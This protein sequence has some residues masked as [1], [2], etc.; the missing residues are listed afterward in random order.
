MATIESLR[1][2]ARKFALWCSIALGWFG[3]AELIEPT[4]AP[5]SAGFLLSSLLLLLIRH[6]LLPNGAE[7]L[8]QAVLS[9]ARGGR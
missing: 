3:A 6:L 9:K 5:A 1:G 8:M 2:K 7:E 4:N